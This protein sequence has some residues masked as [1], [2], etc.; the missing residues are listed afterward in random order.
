MALPAALLLERKVKVGP[1]HRFQDLLVAVAADLEIGGLN[2]QVRKGDR[3]DD[4][5]HP[6]PPLL[7]GENTLEAFDQSSFRHESP[8]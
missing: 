2:R 4:Q 3:K 7:R 6:A 5:N 8:V 1:E